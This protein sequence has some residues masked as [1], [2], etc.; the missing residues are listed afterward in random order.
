MQ[1]RPDSIFRLYVAAVSLFGTGGAIAVVGFDHRELNASLVAIV[2]VC[3][4]VALECVPIRVPRRGFTEEITS[5]LTFAFALLLAFGLP[6]A[7]VAQLLASAA[8]DRRQGKSLQRILFNVGQCGL[9]FMAAGGVLYLLSD[10]PRDGSVPFA[11]E[12]IPAIVAAALV[13]FAC[14]NVLVSVVSAL[15]QGIPIQ[16]H[17]KHDAPFQASIAL[18]LLGMSPVVV[19]VCSFSLWLLPLLL[20]PM[21]AV[22]RAG[23]AA[24]RDHHR[25]LHDDLTGLPNRTHF[26]VRAKSALQA[27]SPDGAA[28]AFLV[29]DLD[30]FKEINDTLGHHQGDELLRRVATRLAGVMREDETTARFGG[31]EFAVVSPLAGGPADVME[32]ADRVLAAFDAPFHL[33]DLQLTVDA[34]VGIALWPEHGEDYAELLRRADVALYQSKDSPLDIVLYDPEN[35]SAGVD[36]LALLTELRHGIDAGELRLVYMPKVALSSG[37]VLGMEALVRWQHP[38]RG[39]LAPGVF[40]P[41]AERTGLI[42]ALTLEVLDQ[43]LAQTARWIAAG[44]ATRVA[45]NLSARTLLDRG[46]PAAVDERLRRFGVPADLLELEITE[47]TIMADPAR[48]LVVL[49]ELAVMGIHL[50]IDDFGTGYSSLA[51]L[52]RLPVTTLKIDR[53]FVTAMLD[54]GQ[55][56]LIVQSTINLAR[57][58]GLYVVAEGIE[59]DA[60]RLELAEL[61]CHA[62]QGYVYG[63]PAAADA[64][65]T[66]PASLRTSNA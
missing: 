10:I 3:V 48:A 60:T 52:K 62:G 11:P 17:I 6:M 44:T 24:V 32:V 23:L 40:I 19:L 30:R 65:Q 20:L 5:S 41:H 31:D 18:L 1:G 64:L 53:S 63:P 42:G 9:A 58:L 34:S 25:A 2:L 27:A 35:D 12:D 22:H 4:T 13:L 59:D 14:N 43:A 51:Y 28:V 8:T 7:L 26:G 37:R 21:V 49:E 16:A 57:N 61:G 39:L 45:V 54:D 29:L 46:L 38:V 55:D 66:P 47:S 56:A 33:D 50:T 15:S 36:R